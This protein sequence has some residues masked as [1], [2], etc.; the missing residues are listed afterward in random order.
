MR[1]INLNNTVTY[2]TNNA[3]NFASSTTLRLGNGLGSRNSYKN[4][5]YVQ[6]KPSM[7]FSYSGMLNTA[8]SHRHLYL[9]ISTHLTPVHPEAGIFMLLSRGPLRPASPLKKQKY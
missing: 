9:K 8:L 6:T 5:F 4:V 1:L 2:W 3:Q 7:N